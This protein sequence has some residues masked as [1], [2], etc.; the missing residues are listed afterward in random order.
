MSQ[1][2][3]GFWQGEKQDLV[4]YA[5]GRVEM[6][7]HKYSSYSGSYRL[8]GKTQECDFDNFAYPVAR[9]VKLSGDKLYLIDKNGI[10]EVYTR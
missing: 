2:L 3:L 4:L 7:D 10:K 6:N 1:E 8:N 9:E 5:D